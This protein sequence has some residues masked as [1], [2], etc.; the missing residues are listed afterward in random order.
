[1]AVNMPEVLDK[2]TMKPYRIL[3]PA[4]MSATLSIL[5]VASAELEVLIS[6]GVEFGDWVKIYFPNG[7]VAVYRCGNPTYNYENDKESVRLTHGSSTLAD[8][9]V[10]EGYKTDS[11]GKAEDTYFSG[12]PKTVVE[13]ILTYQKTKHWKVGTIQAT[14]NVKVAVEFPDALT[15]LNDVV[16]QL[17]GYYIDFDQTSYPWSVNILKVPTEVVAEG[18][19][20]RNVRS[21]EVSYDDSDL[22]TRLYCNAL[23]NKKIDSKNIS[24][25]GIREQFLYIAEN[26]EASW[27]TRACEVYLKNRE[28]PQISVNIDGADFSKLTGVSLDK[29]LLGLMYRLAIPKY[30]TIVEEQITELQYE[31]LLLRPHD[32]RITL[33]THRKDLSSALAET[34]TAASSAGRSAGR[35]KA[36]TQQAWNQFIGDVAGLNT[37]ISQTATMIRLEA[38]DMV[39]Q[40][41]SELTITAQRIRSE[42]ADTQNGFESFIEQTANSIRAQVNDTVN[43]LQSALTITSSGI[44]A[45]VD[46]LQNDMGAAISLNREQIALRVRK[47]DVATALTVE[48]GNVK[49]SNGNLIVEG[50]VTAEAVSTAIGRI[51]H[52]TVPGTLTVYT[53][54]MKSGGTEKNVWSGIE[55]LEYEKTEGNTVYLKYT[56]FNGITGEVS[57]SKAAL[58][59]GS[60][61]GGVYT[62]SPN[63]RG[64][65]TTATTT[66]A[67]GLVNLQYNAEDTRYEGYVGY[68]EDGEYI[69]TGKLVWVSAIEAFQAGQASVEIPTPTYSEAWKKGTYTVKADGTAIKAT[70]LNSATPGTVTYLSSV[71]WLSFP[72]AIGSSGG[73]TGFAPTINIDAS[74]AYN[75]GW[76]GYHASNKW[77]IEADSKD[78][79]KKVYRPKADPA[80][81]TA[82]VWFKVMLNAEWGT[83]PGSSKIKDSNKFTY[84]VQRKIGE[85]SWGNMAQNDVTISLAQS[86]DTVYCKVGALNVAKLDVVPSAPTLTSWFVGDGYQPDTSGGVKFVESSKARFNIGVTVNGTAKSQIVTTNKSFSLGKNLRSGYVTLKYGSNA[87]AYLKLPS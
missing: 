51:D 57:F 8:N 80:A 17:P 69:S 82:E 33:G 87:I 72:V 52:L 79:T 58:L 11:N 31:D 60:W 76:A 22:C 64:S 24:K 32:V 43:G 38:N 70:T 65:S 53:L 9:I 77:S 4:R 86:G 54:K 7:K 20:S 1:M 19:L 34:T 23:P 49:V 59:R 78:T 26:T 68:I 29:V 36:Q 81:T 42:L 16:D 37:L 83:K 74:K 61:S 73:D 41:H 55:N 6:E 85:G 71:K 14:D 15:L 21:A 18:R 2:S 50:M 25:Y 5:S 44:N 3:H 27:V 47:G 28:K 12:S 45:R 30:K 56:K 75:A 62:A 35:A 63:A 48:V 13:K 67:P 46:D 40:L 39:N 10:T 84:A 66:L